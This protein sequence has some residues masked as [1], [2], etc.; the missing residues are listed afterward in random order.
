[1][2]GAPRTGGAS[3]AHSPSSTNRTSPAPSL[4][5]R[6]STVIQSPELDTALRAES[7]FSSAKASH[8]RRPQAHG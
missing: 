2:L 1:M 4:S 8:G 5:P 7:A 3:P 6:D